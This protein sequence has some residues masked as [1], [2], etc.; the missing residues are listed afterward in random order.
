MHEGLLGTARNE[1]QFCDKVKLSPGLTSQ[2][3][4]ETISQDRQCTNNVTS[5]HVCATV[6]AVEKQRVL[7][8]LCVFVAL[9]IQH[10]MRCVVLSSVA[11]PDLQRSSALSH[12]RN[13]F[14]SLKD[15]IRRRYKI[16]RRCLYT[17]PPYTRLTFRRLMSTIV[18]VPHR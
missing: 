2:G 7:H 4:G 8:S 5:R 18:D 9:I 15:R 17:K 11:Y 6:V 1:N 12:K 13:A 16:R 10:A 3:N 14:I